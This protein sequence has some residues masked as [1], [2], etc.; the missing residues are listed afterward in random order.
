MEE[1]LTVNDISRARITNGYGM[2]T[3]AFSP[4]NIG[5]FDSSSVQRRQQNESL[6]VKLLED[7]KYQSYVNKSSHPFK[8][9]LHL[10]KCYPETVRRLKVDSLP[11]PEES[12]RRKAQESHPVNP[13]QV[14][15]LTKEYGFTHAKMEYN[16]FKGKE[17]AV[18]KIITGDCPI[19]KH[20]PLYPQ[21]AT[22]TQ[23]LSIMRASPGHP[24]APA[25]S[26]PKPRKMS[27][28]W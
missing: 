5:I 19:P 27:A 24:D 25:P 1:R 9:T 12:S 14:Q 22:H 20:N 4:S 2:N 13:Q 11:L 17:S 6:K 28:L 16:S 7:A 26:V 3:S 23:L 21:N 10:Q 8:K 15:K 18:D